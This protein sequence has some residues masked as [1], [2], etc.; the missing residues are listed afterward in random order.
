MIPAKD[1]LKF[2]V[3]DRSVV[4][5]TAARADGS[6]YRYDV[7]GIDAPDAR[8]IASAPTLIADMADAIT[9]QAA[10]IARLTERAEKAEAERDAALA[11]G[12]VLEGAMASLLD[13]LKLEDEDG[14]RVIW[15]GA[16]HQ[17]TLVKWTTALKKAHAALKGDAA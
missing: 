14:E 1:L 4:G 7:V 5:E 9:A 3:G 17:H 12:A 15:V 8:L 6:V 16:Q 13:Q 10:E 2:E 11:R